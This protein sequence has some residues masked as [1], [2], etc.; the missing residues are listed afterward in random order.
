METAIVAVGA[1]WPTTGVFTGEE[2]RWAKNQ[3]AAT[4]GDGDVK[5]SD[6]SLGPATP[7]FG[8]SILQLPVFDYSGSGFR[9][10]H[11]ITRDHVGLNGKREVWLGM[12]EMVITGIFESIGHDNVGVPKKR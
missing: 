7:V 2:L 3:V 8:S 6:E 5:S 1:A 9:T 11:T 4:V 12:D 10:K